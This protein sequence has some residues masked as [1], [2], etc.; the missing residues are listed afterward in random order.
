MVTAVVKHLKILL[1]LLLNRDRQVVQ[2]MIIG[3]E[4]CCCE[5]D[6]LVTH[7]CYLDLQRRVVL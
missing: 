4:L 1:K 7:S 6:T 3:M 2:S 5:T